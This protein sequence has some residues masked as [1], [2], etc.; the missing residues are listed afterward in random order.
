MN[1]T[2]T[3]LVYGWIKSPNERGTIDIIWNCVST[4][5]LCSWSVLLLNVPSK[6]GFRAY[7]G[8]KLSWMT[9]AIFFPE[10]LA[11]LAQGQWLSAHQSVS[12]FSSDECLK[13]TL[14]HAFFANMGGF[15][16]E[17]PDYVPFPVN[18]N[19]IR[20]L[21]TH[22]FMDLPIIE[23]EEIRDKNKADAF[24]RILMTIQVLWFTLSCIGRAVQRLSI[25]TFEIDTAAFIFCTF[26]T[27]YFWLY[28][29]LDVSNTITLR[30]KDG[31]RVQDVLVSA[32]QR[33]NEPFNLTPLDFIRADPDPY[34]FLGPVMWG[35]GLLFNFGTDSK[36][37]PI[38]TFKDSSRY[39]TPRYTRFIDFF[40]LCF[41]VLGYTGIHIVAWGFIFPTPTE[42]TLWRIASMILYAAPCSY[43][44]M[45]ILLTWNLSAFC[46]WFG[47]TEAKTVT[48]LLEGL[49]P[50]VQ[51]VIASA[52]V[53]S[54][55]VARLYLLVEAFIGL[56][57]LPADAFQTVDWA[58]ILPHL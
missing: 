47:V 36:H 30:L 45:L 25:S 3:S 11:G 1:A 10:L 39:M 35:V 9:F 38:T 44:L 58:S 51:Y 57:V 19:H 50:V 6:P 46:K 56:R 49:H 53:G 13:W 5:F 7:L 16:L 26:P 22:G 54:Y 42:Q 8:Q 29:P 28:K 33:A 55:G 24:A 41:I 4:V 18:S 21:V 31:I 40:V 15:R 27:I 23:S 14:Y 43:G 34:E 37:G 32:G 12:D 17:T 48:H 20:Y 52:W 2:S